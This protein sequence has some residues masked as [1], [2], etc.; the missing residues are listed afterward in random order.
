MTHL[1]EVIVQ[2]AAIAHEDLHQRAAALLREETAEV[3]ADP[4]ARALPPH[5]DPRPVE[6]PPPGRRVRP[7]GRNRSSQPGGSGG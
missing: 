3:E 7:P 6:A 2:R 1:H 5:P 4:A